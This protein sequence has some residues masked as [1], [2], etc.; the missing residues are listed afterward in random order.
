MG[1]PQ[2]EYTTSQSLEA[3]VPTTDPLFLLGYAIIIYIRFV[4]WRIRRCR[5]SRVGWDGMGCLVWL[6]V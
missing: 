6:C 4:F 2:V 3:I 1:H 5:F